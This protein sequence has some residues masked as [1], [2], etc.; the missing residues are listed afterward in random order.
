MLVTRLKEKITFTRADS[1][2]KNTKAIN[3]DTSY[4]KKQKIISD[5]MQSPEG[6][7]IQQ[8]MILI[9][10]NEHLELISQFYQNM[11]DPDLAKR[12]M[13]GVSLQTTV[14]QMMKAEQ[15][16]EILKNSNLL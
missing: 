12:M 6:K 1:K 10:A 5:M 4:M 14:S 11:P 7:L 16:L 8:Q 15:Q 3:S 2:L 13:I 9:A